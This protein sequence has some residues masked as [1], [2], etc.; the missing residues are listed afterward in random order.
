MLQLLVTTI[1]TRIVVDKSGIALNSV[2]L[3]KSVLQPLVTSILISKEVSKEKHLEDTYMKT[4]ESQ[5][6][7]KFELTCKVARLASDLEAAKSD[8]N[9]ALNR[10]KILEER[11]KT[12]EKEVSDKMTKFQDLVQESLMDKDDIISCLQSELPVNKAMDKHPEYSSS[13]HDVIKLL[14]T[15][16]LT[17]IVVDKSGIALNKSVLQP[18]V[19]SILVSVALNSVALNKSVLQSLVTSILVSVALNK[20]VLQPLVTSILV[21][22]AL[23][24][25]SKEVS[26]EKHLEDTYMK[27]VESQEKE[28]FELTCK[29]ARLASDLEAAKSDKNLALNRQK[30]LEERIKTLEKEVSDKM[31]KFQDLVQEVE[32]SSI[33][34]SRYESL[35]S[36]Q[37]R[38][39]EFK[40]QELENIRKELK[41]LWCAHNQLT[42]HSGQQADLI[43]QLQ[44]LQQDTQKMLKSQEDAF[45]LENT[46]LQQMFTDVNVR[47]ETAKRTEAELRQQILELKKSLMDKD[48]IISSLQSELPVNKAMDKHPE[49]SSSF[50]DIVKEVDVLSPR[51]FSQRQGRCRSLSRLCDSANKS[52]LSTSRARSL[53]PPVV[54]CEQR[55]EHVDMKKAA[56]LQKGLLLKT[57]QLEEMR[58]AHDNRL[59]RLQDLQASYRLAREEIKTLEFGR[60]SKPEK[61][62][63]ADPRSLQK[64]NSDEVW[65]ELA[66]FKSENRTLQ[67]DKM[68][69]QE[70]VDLL[71]VQTAHDDATIHELKLELQTQREEF[72]FR[73][74]QM[75]REKQDVKE[76]EKQIAFLKTQIQSKTLLIEKLQKDL[77]MVM[78]QKDDVTQEKSKLMSQLVATQQDASHHR[79]ELADVRYQLQCVEHQLEDMRQLAADVPKKTFMSENDQSDIVH[80]V[81]ASLKSK[82]NNSVE[83]TNNINRNK[84]ED[85]AT[86]GFTKEDF[87]RKLTSDESDLDPYYL[88]KGN[89]AARKSKEWQLISGSN[90]KNKR[91][92]GDKSPGVSS[93]SVSSH[94]TQGCCRDF[95]TSPITFLSATPDKPSQITA[96]SK[97]KHRSGYLTTFNRMARKAAESKQIV[98]LQ[99]RVAQLVNQVAILKKAKTEAATREETLQESVNKLQNE[100]LSISGRMKS[101]K[102]LAQKLQSD[103]DKLQKEK[104]ELEENVKTTNK[105]NSGTDNPEMKS[106]EGK[107]KSATNELTKQTATVKELKADKDNLQE[108]VK[109]L[110]D[111]INHLERDVNQKRNLLENQRNKL[112][113]ADEISKT[114]ADNME[115]LETKV[116]LLTDTNNKMKVQIE[117]LRKRLSLAVNEKKNY[118][119]K[120]LKVSLDLEHKTKQLFDVSSQRLALE[121]ALSDL[122]SSAKQ[123]LHGLAFQSE[124]AIDTAR[125]KLMIAQRRLVQFH[126]VVKMLATELLNRTGAARTKLQEMKANEESLQRESDPSL[127]KA[128]KKAKDILQLSQSDLEDIMSADGD[129]YSQE[130]MLAVEKKLGRKWLRK[131]EKLLNSGE[132]FVNPLVKLLLQKVDERTEY[133]IQLPR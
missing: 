53:S 57:K 97:P 69:L 8:K 91:H 78:T 35:T 90:T 121:S 15:T 118:E 95:A 81:A 62:K 101:S 119:D 38:D 64:E 87:E 61:I 40:N 79:M 107:L 24:Q 58:R 127:Q 51:D 10:Q 115:E 104:E 71:R 12:L 2:A 76:A 1:L 9:L 19:T 60:K 93:G 63:R 125:E 98:A 11:I 96:K 30:I 3:N 122:E 45:S 48:D 39:L 114:D 20:S 102:Q 77:S 33:R 59:Q 37:R 31:T 29:V 47:Y 106:L 120:F 68:S 85:T 27:T 111:K 92:C 56:H 131:C 75:Q 22:V 129:N 109:N 17:R 41:E 86:H 25:V 23:K 46:S 88:N 67:I 26:K 73:L 133:L 50:L 52:S 123:Q 70:E 6:K 5:E 16:I 43:R 80:T 54:I 94:H 132:D 21:T 100:L 42:E 13:F 14:V 74:H 110:Q 18:L 34:L 44:S 28:K 99:Q 105:K 126:A 113:H 72:E 83:K 116:K 103:I 7:E 36:Q 49:Y 112:K 117:S 108:Q 4:V 55:T 130:S 82:K 65:N 124:A 128:Q 84:T 32:D 89:N 66:F